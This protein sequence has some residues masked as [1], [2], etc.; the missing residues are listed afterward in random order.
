LANASEAVKRSQ[1]FSERYI[2]FCTLEHS[3]LASAY[4]RSR[5]GRTSV[6]RILAWTILWK[7]AP[8]IPYAGSPKGHVPGSQ[9]RHVHFDAGDSTAIWPRGSS[10]RQL[11]RMLMRQF[12]ADD[13]FMLNL[14]ILLTSW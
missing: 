14:W 2:S 6:C 1:P 3:A 5:S 13:R 8:T 11:L 12:R 10:S 9:L 7:V 4:L